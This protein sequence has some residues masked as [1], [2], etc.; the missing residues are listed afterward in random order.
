LE[1]L[2]RS[3]KK[4]VKLE[5]TGDFGMGIKVKRKSNFSLLNQYRKYSKL[6]DLMDITSPK[7]RRYFGHKTEVFDKKGNPKL[8]IFSAPE[9]TDYKV[10]KKKKRDKNWKVL[11][12]KKLRYG[13]SAVVS[14]N[15]K[16]KTLCIN[17]FYRTI[18]LFIYITAEEI[19][20]IT[21]YLNI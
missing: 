18:V 19:H 1:R 21:K 12:T 17:V 2:S 14:A 9:V 10:F 20:V 4:L 3:F 16:T 11:F 15:R 6:K 13:A 5:S 8:L 7:Y